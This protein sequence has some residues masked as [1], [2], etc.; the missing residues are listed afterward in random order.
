M[1]NRFDWTRGV[2][3]TFFNV[4]AAL[5]L[6]ACFAITGLWVRSYSYTD[7]ISDV[8]GS[9]VRYLISM[10]GCVVVGLGV[11]KYPIEE[12]NHDALWTTDPLKVKVDWD[13]IWR[14]SIPERVFGYGSET[15]TRYVGSPSGESYL[16]V[17]YRKWGLAY[18]TLFLIT[19]AF[20]STLATIRLR[21]R[22]VKVRRSRMGL[23]PRCGYDLRA[24]PDRCP[25][26]G[27]ACLQ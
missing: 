7:V 21:K 19:A 4:L 10:G 13:P 23:C 26:C 27:A 6:A 17:T 9:Q 25:E 15:A 11:K 24:S 22:L 18:R 14:H 5:S 2:W 3:R 1:P 16:P 8:H 12:Q 20:P